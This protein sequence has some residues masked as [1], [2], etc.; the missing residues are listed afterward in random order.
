MHL[1]IY[2]YGNRYTFNIKKK[3]ST[4]MTSHIDQLGQYE[5]KLYSNY[6]LYQYNHHAPYTI[7][8][9]NENSKTFIINSSKLMID[10]YLLN[11]FDNNERIVLLTKSLLLSSCNN[12]KTDSHSS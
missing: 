11:L 7:Y 8:C 10:S 2:I 4:S 5:G 1:Y 6:V 3:D 12:S 9:M